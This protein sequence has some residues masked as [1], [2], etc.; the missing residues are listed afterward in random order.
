MSQ[1]FVHTDR[2]ESL[3]QEFSSVR[4]P[5]LYHVMRTPIPFRASL[6]SCPEQEWEEFLQRYPALGIS[7]FIAPGG[8]VQQ[9]C[10]YGDEI[11][12]PVYT[13]LASR[14]FLEMPSYLLP[15]ASSDRET[16][17]DRDHFTLALYRL[18]SRNHDDIPLNCHGYGSYSTIALGADVLDVLGLL[19]SN[20]DQE[21]QCLE[22]WLQRIRNDG[23]QVVNH[24]YAGL[25]VDVFAAAAS[26]LEMVI[27]ELRSG[28]PAA[29]PEEAAVSNQ[30]APPIS[31]AE[32]TKRHM[33]SPSERTIVEILLEQQRRMT[34]EQIIA[35]IELRLG[36]ASLGTTKVTLAG[37]R[38]RGILDNSRHESPPGYGI[39]TP[40]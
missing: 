35:E 11:A 29:A 8:R 21:R 23:G 25:G 15:L 27:G 31:L 9:S 40:P 36:A 14:A 13:S 34:T 39:A 18:A 7:Q 20:A 28:R 37:L 12:L 3:R 32:I 33:L 5:G 38:R 22:N 26:G 19:C 17:T 10:F 24:V 16:S 4:N 2:L 6:D 1:S 30:S